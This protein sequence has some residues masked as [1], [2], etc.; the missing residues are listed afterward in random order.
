[1]SYHRRR[2]YLPGIGLFLGACALAQSAASTAG[3][4]LAPSGIPGWTVIGLADF[5]GDGHPDLIWQNPSTGQVFASYM[6]GPLGSNFLGAA[7]LANPG[8]PG[9]TANAR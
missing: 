8:M 6:G 3:I 7:F 5:N 9:W 1:M 2:V 4:H